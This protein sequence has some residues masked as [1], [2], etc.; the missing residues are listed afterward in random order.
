M[1]RPL[2]QRVALGTSDTPTGIEEGR[3]YPDMTVS[4]GLLPFLSSI[5]VASDSTTSTVGCLNSVIYSGAS[6]LF[7]RAE[8]SYPSEEGEGPCCPTESTAARTGAWDA[9][10]GLGVLN[11]TR[12]QEILAS[13]PSTISSSITAS[14]SAPFPSDGSWSRKSFTQRVDRA[15]GSTTTISGSD[16]IPQTN[17]EYMSVTRP[18]P[19]Q[20]QSRFQ[21]HSDTNDSLRSSSSVLPA[22]LA[23]PIPLSVDASQTTYTFYYTGSYQSFYVPAGVTSI[24]VTAY[25]AQGA[26]TAY[27]ALGDTAGILRPRFPL[28]PIPICTSMWEGRGV[29]PRED[30]TAGE[31]VEVVCVAEVEAPQMS[32]LGMRM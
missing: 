8:S 32:E 16:F 23:K 2:F 18:E 7:H 1:R 29:D 20:S 30:T 6:D 4:Q 3:L 31:T 27:T 28:H 21:S 15:L 19:L 9:S 13:P 11:L 5:L 14:I 17:P 10:V 22:P 24:T 25:G 12:F 26:S